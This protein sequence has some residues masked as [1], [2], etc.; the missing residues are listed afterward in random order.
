MKRNAGTVDS[1][2]L[3]NNFGVS[4]LLVRE[5]TGQAMKFAFTKITQVKN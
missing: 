5:D 3:S 4:Y 2:L 1:L